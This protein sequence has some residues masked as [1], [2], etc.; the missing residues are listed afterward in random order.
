MSRKRGAFAW[1]DCAVFAGAIFLAGA[2]SQSGPEVQRD[3]RAQAAAAATRFTPREVQ[4]ARKLSLA[5]DQ[6]LAEASEY[7]RA[8]RCHKALI[9]MDQ[10]LRKTGSVT[11]EQLALLQQARDLFERRARQH[12][13]QEGRSAAAILQQLQQRPTATADLGNE[14]RTGLACVRTL[15]GEA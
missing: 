1:A 12:G 2:C 5:G 13:L 14:A 9:S 3:R 11:G 6:L 4:A 7:E 10:T 8:L 15:Q